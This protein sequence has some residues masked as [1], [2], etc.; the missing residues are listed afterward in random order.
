MNR[1]CANDLSVDE[2]RR[3]HEMLQAGGK[4]PEQIIQELR[5]AQATL[6]DP[7]QF[8][9]DIQS[10]VQAIMQENRRGAA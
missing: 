2:V 3:A 4:T 5:G 9:R 6:L 8:S 1:L 7:S 10:R